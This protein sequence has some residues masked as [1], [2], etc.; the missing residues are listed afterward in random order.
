MTKIGQRS[1]TIYSL[2]L[3]DSARPP[4]A[5]GLETLPAGRFSL[6]VADSDESLAW[7][8]KTG[9]SATAKAAHPPLARLSA[10]ATLL[11]RLGPML[12]V[13]SEQQALLDILAR[14]RRVDGTLATEGDLFSLTLHAP[15]KP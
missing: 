13:D 2:K 11:S 10:D 15:L 5:V 7:A 6:S 14:L 9:D 3:P 1:P 8:Y 12:S 4:L